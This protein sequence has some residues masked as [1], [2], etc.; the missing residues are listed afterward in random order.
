MRRGGALHREHLL[1]RP[2][3]HR[4]FLFA[5]DHQGTLRT[6][7]ARQEGMVSRKSE[8]EEET[9]TQQWQAV[10]VNLLE[11]LFESKQQP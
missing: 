5:L 3:R 7:R 11:H 4:R 8:T 2:L 1:E 6:G 9:V 10:D